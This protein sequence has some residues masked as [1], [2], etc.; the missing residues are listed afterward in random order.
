M[1]NQQLL[2]EISQVPG[3]TGC[4]LT[5]HNGQVQAHVLK[6]QMTPEELAPLAVSLFDN[7][8]VQIKRLQRGTLNRLVIESESGLMVMSNAP[9][10]IV[11][12]FVSVI[13]G[14]NLNKL[15]STMTTLTGV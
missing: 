1:D 14:F 11:L 4:I 8:A 7:L 2:N 6:N 15:L 5:S 3:V 10:G 12:V 9:T 13:E